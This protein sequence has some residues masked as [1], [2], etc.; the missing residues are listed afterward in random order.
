[1]NRDIKI[2]TR[3]AWSQR[4]LRHPARRRNVLALRRCDISR[5][6]NNQCSS[7]IHHSSCS[8]TDWQPM[9]P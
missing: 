1:M 7:L 5:S 3:R 2:P 4:L 6:A 8:S 9:R